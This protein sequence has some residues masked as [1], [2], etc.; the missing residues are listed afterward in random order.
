ML[1]YIIDIPYERRKSCTEIGLQINSI[2]DVYTLILCYNKKEH[3]VLFYLECDEKCINKIC[4]CK[5]VLASTIFIA[6]E[7]WE[8]VVINDWIIYTFVEGRETYNKIMIN[9]IFKF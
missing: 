8:K 3:K 4:V 2:E 9:R 5:I 7:F 6:Q 1:Q